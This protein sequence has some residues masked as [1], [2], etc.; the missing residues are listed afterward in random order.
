MT[1]FR[2]AFVDSEDDERSDQELEAL[3]SQAHFP[4][5]PS[6]Y[7]AT[8]AVPRPRHADLDMRKVMLA[9][10]G[11]NYEIVLHYADTQMRPNSENIPQR[12]MWRRSQTSQPESKGKVFN[13]VC[14]RNVCVLYSEHGL[15]W[16]CWRHSP[17]ICKCAYQ[18]SF[19]ISAYCFMCIA[20][21]LRSSML[22]NVSFAYICI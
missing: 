16:K 7:P 15:N 22:K 12:A 20:C 10:G 9:A 3:S 21:S 18:L 19:F 1:D 14:S 5:P 13:A 2:A 11:S 17:S 8:P 4:P 6:Q